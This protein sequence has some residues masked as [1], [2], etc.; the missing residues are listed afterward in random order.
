MVQGESWK[1][2]FLHISHGRPLSLPPTPVTDRPIGGRCQAGRCAGG[3][4]PPERSEPT[5]LVSASGGRP[6]TIQV[7]AGVL[8]PW[9]WL[10]GGGYSRARR[11]ERQ[12][13]GRWTSRLVRLRYSGL[14]QPPNY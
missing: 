3:T 10:L 6:D 4:A 1:S 14:S 7:Q 11:T 5:G 9:R 12:R 13:L 8:G 2:G